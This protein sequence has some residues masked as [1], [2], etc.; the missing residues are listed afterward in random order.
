[1]PLSAMSQRPLFKNAERQRVPI[2]TPPGDRTSSL[3]NSDYMID[4]ERLP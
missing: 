3:V 4:E 1:M 2:L